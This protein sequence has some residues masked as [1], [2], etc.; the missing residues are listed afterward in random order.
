MSGRRWMSKGRNIGRHKRPANSGQ[1]DDWELGLLVQEAETK[2][3]DC[4]DKGWSDNFIFNSLYNENPTSSLWYI[5]EIFV[6]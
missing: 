1:C 3:V 6:C 2:K 4:E 5:I